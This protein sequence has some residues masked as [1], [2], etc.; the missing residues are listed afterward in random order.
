[1]KNFG[2]QADKLRDAA[3][4]KDLA[5]T[6]PSPRSSGARRAGRA[7]PPFRVP[8]PQQQGA[9]AAASNNRRADRDPREPGRAPTASSSALRL[10]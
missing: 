1:V 4:T 10:C 9:G 2:S 3:R 6:G 5:A 7:T 8:P